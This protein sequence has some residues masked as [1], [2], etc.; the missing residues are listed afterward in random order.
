VGFESHRENDLKK[1]RK[2]TT[3]SRNEEVVRILNANHI[4]VA[5]NFILQQDYS[6]DDFKQAADYIRTL[7]VDTPS[8]SI[9]TPL[10]GTEIYAEEE[11]DYP[12][13]RFLRPLPYRIAH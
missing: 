12:R 5:G 4:Q 1:M 3:L 2:G 9:W 10:P 13:L 8:F 6:E 11:P 7:E